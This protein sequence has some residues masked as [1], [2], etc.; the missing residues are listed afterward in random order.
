MIDRRNDDT[1][2]FESIR[3]IAT[4]KRNYYTT[5]CFL[6]W[7]L[8]KCRIAAEECTENLGDTFQFPV[9]F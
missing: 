4:D 3:K 7:T 9:L 6:N 2:A 8:G 1:K 5:G